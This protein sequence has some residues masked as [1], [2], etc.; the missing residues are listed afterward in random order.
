MFHPHSSAPPGKLTG[1]CVDFCIYETFSVFTHF[2]MQKL[3]PTNQKKYSSCIVLYTAGSHGGWDD[4][5][6][7]C[8][9]DTDTSIDFLAGACSSLQEESNYV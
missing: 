4:E 8:E 1:E 6:T 3:K 9:K 7:F 5:T 2:L